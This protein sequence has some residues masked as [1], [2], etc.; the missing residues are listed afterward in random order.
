MDVLNIFA[1]P[2]EVFERI[3]SKPTW[4]VPFFV[5][6]IGTSIVVWLTAPAHHQLAIASLQED[7]AGF[8]VS[9]SLESPLSRFLTITISVIGLFLR[10]VIMSGLLYFICILAGAQKGLRFRSI[11]S[12]LLYSWM[13]ILMWDVVN[14]LLLY[15][16]GIESISHPIELRAP[17]GLDFFLEDR[18]TNPLLAKFLNTINPFSLWFVVTLTIGVS[19]VSGLNLV[20]AASIVLIVWSLGAGYDVTRAAMTKGEKTKIII[21]L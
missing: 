9:R 12:A 16:Q 11:F 18:T 13:I 1:T 20:R 19:V 7:L 17:V 4:T 8:H 3:K 10:W 2:K 6:V 5:L 14:V 21:N 15:L